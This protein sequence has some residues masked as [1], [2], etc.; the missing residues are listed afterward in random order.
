MDM[1]E[2][3]IRILLALLSISVIS[4]GQDDCDSLQCSKYAATGSYIVLE[5]L[6]ISESPASTNYMISCD[7]LC[8]IEAARSIESDKIIILNNYKILVYKR[9]IY[10]EAKE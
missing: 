5:D 2:L 3:R 4:F 9:E 7:M 1:K 8:Q 6:T 10:T